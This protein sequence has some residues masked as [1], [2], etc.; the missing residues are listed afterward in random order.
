[1][2]DVHNIFLNTND[3]KPPIDCFWVSSTAEQVNVQLSPYMGRRIAPWSI[4]LES[5]NIFDL[6][7]TSI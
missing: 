6:L 2:A 1:M 5:K 4:P 7:P 3:S